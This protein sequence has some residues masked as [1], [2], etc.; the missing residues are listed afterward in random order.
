M[1]CLAG[2]D[3]SSDTKDKE[4]KEALGM[5]ILKILGLKHAPKVPK[6]SRKKVSQFI[7]DAYNRQVDESE[8][9]GTI[10]STIG[11]RAPQNEGFQIDEQ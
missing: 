10:T 6:G 3:D 9:K 7:L 5:A 4:M 8:G 2:Q 11:I 1:I